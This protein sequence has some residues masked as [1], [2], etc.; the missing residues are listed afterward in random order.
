M[1]SRMM[2]ALISDKIL[3][4]ITVENNSFVLLGGLAPDAAVKNKEISHFYTGNHKKY[5]RRIDYNKF[6]NKYINA[7][8]RDYILGYYCHLIADDLWLTGF[9]SPWLKNRIESN[10]ETLNAY[11]E[12]FRLLNGKLSEHYGVA[13]KDFDIHIPNNLMNI[14]EVEDDELN[15]FLHL[16]QTD[17]DYNHE[18]L[19]KPLTVFTLEQ[20]IGYIE[21]AVAKSIYCLKDKAAKGNGYER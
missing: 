1:G 5:T 4:E 12:D 10:E 8:Q 6:Y 2:H 18:E 7:L 20:M 21:T 13:V 11:H 16:I 14:E 17:F 15:Q 9:F 19:E 3:K